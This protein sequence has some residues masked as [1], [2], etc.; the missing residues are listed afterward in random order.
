M[1]QLSSSAVAA[2]KVY[3][4]LVKWQNHLEV[5][6]TTCRLLLSPSPVELKN[7]PTLKGLASPATLD[8][9][10]EFVKAWRED[11]RSSNRNMTLFYFAGHGVQRVRGDHVILLEDFDENEDPILQH[12]VDTTA[13]IDGMAP[14]EGKPDIARTQLY[15]LDA[16]RITPALFAT[17]EQTPTAPL[18]DSK[19]KSPGEEFTAVL[20]YATGPGREAYGIKGEQTLF[21]KALIA[22]LDGGAGYEDDNQLDDQGRPQWFVTTNSINN[23]LE[24]YIRRVNQEINT[25]QTQ[26]FR[27]SGLG[28]AV[29]LHR[30]N[31][32]P[33][34]DITL[35]IVPSAALDFAR[36]EVLNDSGVPIWDLS[37]PLCPHPYFA[38]LAAG[39]YQVGAKIDPAKP[40]YKDYKV[41]RMYVSPPEK[42]WIIKVDG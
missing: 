26:M 32:P 36:V 30:L 41:R 42:K 27:T 24:Y 39:H 31:G 6:L 38:R 4:W 15:F 1:R 19:K 8:N 29:V 16:C 18:W 40:Q 9:F 20:F 34:V 21:S 11:A 22:C 13:L 35:R 5:P 7:E 37:I 2:Y 17:Y 12:A 3:Q 10:R 25:L 23:A 14:I 28:P 33:E